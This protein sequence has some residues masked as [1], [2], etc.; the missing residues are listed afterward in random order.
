MLSDGTVSDYKISD[1]SQI[2]QML[3][4]VPDLSV[5]NIPRTRLIQ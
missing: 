4:V 3:A 5:I 2:N 1:F